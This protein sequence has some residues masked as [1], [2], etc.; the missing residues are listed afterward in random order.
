MS[1][2]STEAKVGLFVLA[3][4]IIL[5]YMSMQIGKRGFGTKK[6]YNYDVLFDNAAGL[7]KEASVQIAGV[8]VGHVESIRLQ[9]GKA[10]ATLRI[11]PEVKLEKDVRAAIKTHGV[12]G[13]FG[14]Q[15]RRAHARR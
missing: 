6:G 10:L 5:G 2:I 13:G 8:E 1:A 3:G 12:L 9:D 14:R 7:N 11:F 15:I 4:F